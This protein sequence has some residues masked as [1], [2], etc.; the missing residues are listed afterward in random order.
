MASF[1]M[2]NIQPQDQASKVTEPTSST[3]EAGR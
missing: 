3:Q 1:R 2:S